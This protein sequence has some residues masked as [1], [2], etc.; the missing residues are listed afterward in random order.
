MRYTELN[1]HERIN[2]KSWLVGLGPQLY[3]RPIFTLLPI[4]LPDVIEQ[5]VSQPYDHETK[6][7]RRNWNVYT[8]YTT[9]YTKEHSSGR[10]EGNLRLEDKED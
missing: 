2:A 5:N 7:F 1:I 6:L 9:I 8:I 10:I 3:R 4:N